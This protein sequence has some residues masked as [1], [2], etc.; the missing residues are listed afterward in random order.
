M[1]AV[2]PFDFL[3]CEACDQQVGMNFGLRNY[4]VEIDQSK[5]SEEDRK[6]RVAP[7][8]Q[9]RATPYCMRCKGPLIQKWC[10]VHVKVNP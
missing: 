5:M 1:S 2:G 10:E 4:R 8:V 3:F 6:N 7:I 9:V